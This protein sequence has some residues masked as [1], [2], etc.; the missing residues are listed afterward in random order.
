M[1]RVLVSHFHV[2]FDRLKL[3]GILLSSNLKRIL[4]ALI[5]VQN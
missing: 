5:D 1:R 2:A 4:V 3:E